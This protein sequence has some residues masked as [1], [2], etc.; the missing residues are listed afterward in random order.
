MCKVYLMRKIIL[1]IIGVSNKKLKED[2]GI[3]LLEVAIGM[4]LLG[5]ITLPLIRSYKIEVVR[6]ANEVSGTSLTL[7]YKAI[8]SFYKSGNSHYP[9]P[10]NL[11][12]KE[13]DADFG[14]AGNCTL[15]SIKPCTAATW[16]STGGICKTAGGS[17]SVIIGGVPFADLGIR[18]ERSLD[19]W[20]NKLI[21]A[22]TFEQTDDLTFLA[23]SGEVN[24]MAVSSNGGAPYVKTDATPYDF[25]IFSTGASAVGG[26][27]K[28]GQ[29]ISACG[30]AATGYDNENCDFDDVFFHGTVNRDGENPRTEIAGPLFFDD[31][32]KSQ[33]SV[34]ED[35]WYQHPDNII[36]PQNF[37][38][39]SA[40]RVGVGTADP[41]ASIHAS[42]PNYPLTS[43]DP[44][45]IRVEGILKSDQICDQGSVNCFNPKSITGN[46]AVMKCDADASLD[47]DQAVVRL[48][49][50]KVT[51]G[52]SVDN[53]GAVIEGEE[54]SVDTAVISGNSSDPNGKGDCAL[55]D[56]VS[57]IDASG[58]IKCVAP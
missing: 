10:A 8:N 13:G 16:F 53:V 55:G 28:N 44:A 52:S 3:S 1:S 18:Q 40:A 38:I 29:I 41:Q 21:Y 47:G 27:T 39:T 19:Y 46:E 24:L 20:N 56:V 15:A 30:S 31:Y 42:N 2:S 14:K 35:M 5:L 12:A 6:K 58:E 37:I 4:V 54:F 45:D 50:N 11:A 32:T 17:N 25:F 9:C 33:E 51:C 43:T 26:Y 36:Y 34:P 22:V 57:G 7:S 23:N 48:A 49:N